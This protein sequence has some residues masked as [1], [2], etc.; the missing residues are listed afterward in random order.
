MAE[1]NAPILSVNVPFKQE[2]NSALT[3]AAVPSQREV[4]A[5]SSIRAVIHADNGTFAEHLA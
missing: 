3:K 4:L 5:P 2:K 1:R